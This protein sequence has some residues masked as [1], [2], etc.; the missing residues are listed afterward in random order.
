MVDASVMVSIAPT[1]PVGYLCAR[2]IFCDQGHHASTIISYDKA[3][4]RVPATDSRHHHHLFTTKEASYNV[5]NR[6]IYLCLELALKAST[7]IYA[8][9]DDKNSNGNWIGISNWKASLE[10]R[11]H[12]QLLEM[13]PYIKALVLLDAYNFKR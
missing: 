13:V 12:D 10:T 8:A 6:L 1:S 7:L 9:A 3:L 2:R 4:Q 11:E 5:V